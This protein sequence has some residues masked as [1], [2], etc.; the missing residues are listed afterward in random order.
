LI[1]RARIINHARNKIGKLKELMQ[2]QKDE[3]HNIVYCGDSNVDGEK[4]IDAVVSGQT[5]LQELTVFLSWL[6]RRHS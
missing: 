2:G 3:S 1:E 6:G 5:L 4:Q